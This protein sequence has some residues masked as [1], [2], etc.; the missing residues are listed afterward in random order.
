MDNVCLPETL[1]DEIVPE[2]DIDDKMSKLSNIAEQFIVSPE[3]GMFLSVLIKV[4]F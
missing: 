1:P 3:P 4:R 2:I